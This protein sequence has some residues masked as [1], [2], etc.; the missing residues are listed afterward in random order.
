MVDREL[1]YEWAKKYFGEENISFTKG[2]EE[3]CTISP[4]S[5]GV[6]HKLWMNPSGGKSKHPENGAYRCWYTD[7]K[8]SLVSLVSQ[9]ENIEW[10]EAEDLIS[11]QTSLRSLEEEL[12]KFFKFENEN[13]KTQNNV[14]KIN[15]PDK[16]FLIDSL[17][18]GSI[19]HKAVA[20]LK[21]RK[22]P[23]DGLFVSFDKE[24]YNR[25]VIPY[26]DFNGDLIWFNARLI[27]NDEN[28]LRYKKP[29]IENVS[30][31]EVL[32]MRRW[33]KKPSEVFVVEGEFDSMSL[34]ICDYYSAACGGKT[35]S[36]NQIN[37]LRNHIPVLAFDADIHGKNA[38]IN[39]G[40][41]LIS[42]GFKEVNYIRPP[43]VFKDWNK[44]L[45]KKD[46]ETIQSY[47]NKNKKRFTSWSDLGL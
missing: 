13:K 14:G 29:N 39:I 34:D 23:T 11:N 24:Y 20:Y 17:N 10:D 30:Q 47:I 15:L 19:Y 43:E 25:I 22:I 45:Q 3:I 16:T 9:L 38:L 26:Y 32:Y 36:D 21:E 2:G 37:I 35:L 6:K 1:F 31:D 4:F 33:P 42:K 5:D 41:D 7:K 8:G 18:N 40:N 28:A 46:I 44:F 27:S 12:N